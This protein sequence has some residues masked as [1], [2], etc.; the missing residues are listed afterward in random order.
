[1][2]VAVIGAGPAG[3]AAAMRLARE[4]ARVTVYESGAEIGG[5][6]RSIDLWNRRVDLGSHVLSDD[7]PGVAD[8][9]RE[10]LGSRIHRVPLRRG[11]MVGTRC[12]TYPFRPIDI[13]RKSGPATS[14]AL[15]NGF[16]R[17]R[18]EAVPSR[19]P[20]SAPS[21]TPESA[22]EWIVAK[23]GRAFHDRFFRPY[24]EKLWGIPSSC[25]DVSFA[26]ALTGAT[27]QASEQGAWAR[28]WGRMHPAPSA[29]GRSKSF[30]YPSDGIGALSEAMAAAAVESG[31]EIL[32][33]TRV[34]RLSVE[35]GSVTALSSGA[36]S[37]T[38]DAVVTAAPLP[39]I[40]R[41]V[42]APSEI[43]EW[44]ETLRTRSTVLVYL[45]VDD[46]APFPELWRY[47]CDPNSSVGRVANL[48]RWQAPRSPGADSR[49]RTLL[50]CE[51]W[52]ET[53][54]AAWTEDDHVV[55][56]SAID[57]LDE[58]GLVDR[59]KVGGTH[60]MRLPATHLV[61]HIGSP[62]AVDAIRSYLGSIQGLYVV[63]R[64]AGLQDVATSL[65]SGLVA[66][67][68][69]LQCPATSNSRME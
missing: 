11:V 55:A 20:E 12:F 15:V 33:S 53:S 16:L 1:M 7:I 64:G 21:R 36:L 68:L 61:P 62:I 44:V 60:V 26:R 51:I 28:A 31:A 32:T 54:D 24:A 57:E 25:I 23:F 38:F 4:R 41:L 18:A 6:A 19:T 43:A 69:V 37:R 2:D 10:L 35:Q 48:A 63:G 27:G 49:P 42:D 8:I 47:L 22:E 52:C 56:Q 39:V 66:A 14:L 13:V 65:R 5:L 59:S 9:L 17:R 46:L 3:L 50:C 45:A 58:A 30:L 29:H 34:E 67:D 40:S